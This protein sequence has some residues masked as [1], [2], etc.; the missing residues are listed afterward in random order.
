V[1]ERVRERKSVKERVRE[2]KREREPSDDPR[3]RS[4]ACE[5][6][7]LRSAAGPAQL[8]IRWERGAVVS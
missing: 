3:S 6:S 8:K 5:I 4:L 7:T 2:R 1:K